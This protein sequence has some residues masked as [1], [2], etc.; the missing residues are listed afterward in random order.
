MGT[1][2]Q[3]TK[4]ITGYRNLEPWPAPGGTIEVPDHEAEDLINAGLARIP[5]ENA[6][7]ID[8]GHADDEATED[9]DEPAGDGPD[10]QAAEN[11]GDAPADDTAPPRAPVKRPA[12]R[13]ARRRA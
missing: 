8:P 3:M 11:S 13:P 7:A 1:L 9:S 10:D 6:D 4:N 5:E 12:K 2:V